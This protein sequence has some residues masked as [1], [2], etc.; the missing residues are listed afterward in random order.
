MRAISLVRMRTHGKSAVSII[1]DPDYDQN[2]VKSV[3]RLIKIFNIIIE[4]YEMMTFDEFADANLHPCMTLESM[5][6]REYRDT[7][8]ELESANRDFWKTMRADQVDGQS[9]V[10]FLPEYEDPL[11]AIDAAEGRIAQIQTDIE[12]FM[13]IVDGHSRRDIA[14]KL[15]RCKLD[16]AEAKRKARNVWKKAI[17]EN[18]ELSLD[19]VEKLDEVQAAFRERDRI[20]A[21]LKPTIADLEKK[22]MEAEEILKKYG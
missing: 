4:D 22:L 13:E 20:V 5:M 12:N 17:Q 9:A 11:M 3:T 10:Y 18:P 7:I 15:N 21:G 19:N 14:E 16:I 2:H 1:F 8:E 6:A